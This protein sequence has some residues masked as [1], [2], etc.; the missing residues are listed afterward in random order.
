MSYSNQSRDLLKDARIKLGLD[1]RE[2]AGLAGVSFKT[3]DNY[4][5]G[6]GRETT[7]SVVCN[8][9]NL[10]RAYM[11]LAEELGYDPG[12]FHESVLCPGEFP[13]PVGV[14]S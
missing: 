4:E 13:A 14:K 10:C 5:K 8:I 11:K 1:L 9:R 2:A 12:Q 6:L 7:A 3:V